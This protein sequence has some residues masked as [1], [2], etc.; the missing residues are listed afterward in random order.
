[1]NDNHFSLAEADAL[2]GPEAIERIKREVAAA[3]RFT[4]E[5]CEKFRALF[6]TV[7]HQRPEQG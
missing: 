3:P 6:A 4:P 7:L 1:M 2:F 5:Q